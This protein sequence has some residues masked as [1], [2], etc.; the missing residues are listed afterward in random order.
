MLVSKGHTS[1]L[2]SV[3]E[4]KTRAPGTKLSNVS[5]ALCRALQNILSSSQPLRLTSLGSVFPPSV[6][7]TVRFPSYTQPAS[8]SKE[9]GV[10][11][12]A[13]RTCQPLPLVLLL[14]LALPVCRSFLCPPTASPS[15]SVFLP[16]PMMS[17]SPLHFPSFLR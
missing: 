9:L 13:P 12:G 14:S 4:S 8:S 17:H 10:C 6:F 1:V 16:F 11:P 15:S 2:A 3:L 7:D 5:S